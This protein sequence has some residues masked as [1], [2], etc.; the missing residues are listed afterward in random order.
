LTPQIAQRAYQL[1]EEEGHDDGHATE[2]WEKAER[3]IRQPVS[4]K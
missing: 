3:E 4:R 1:Y 2:D